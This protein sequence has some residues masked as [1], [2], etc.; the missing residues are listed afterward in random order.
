MK[1]NSGLRLAL[2]LAVPFQFGATT[3]FFPTEAAAKTM[4]G[5]NLSRALGAI[6]VPVNAE[7]I[8][9]FKIKGVTT[10]VMVVSM[11]P[12]G[13]AKDAGLLP[14]DVIT[15]VL[16][17]DITDL[18]TLDEIVFFALDED[19]TEFSYNRWRDGKE[20][21]LKYTV[22]LDDV[23]KPID[24]A[25]IAS[26]TFFDFD[27]FDYNGYLSEYSVELTES[28]DLSQAMV[29]DYAVVDEEAEEIAPAEG[30]AADEAEAEG[31][32]EAEAEGEAEAKG[33]GAGEAEAEGEADEG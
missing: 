28:Y 12:D 33:E 21:V 15:K 25:S 4:T 29:E 22:T 16:G 17:M 2:A 18:V 20:E 10:G 30:E 32:A 14:G 24:A 8:K 31:E 13:A 23:S 9:K 3:M 19:V 26:W 7:T 27:G 6:I 1:I 11:Q 5:T